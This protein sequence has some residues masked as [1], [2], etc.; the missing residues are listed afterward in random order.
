MTRVLDAVVLRQGRLQCNCRLNFR[1]FA[2]NLF[3]LNT[4]EKET[5]T[6]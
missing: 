2:L 4:L 5:S 3:A 1:L 6:A